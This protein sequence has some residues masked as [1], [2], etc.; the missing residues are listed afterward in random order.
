MALMQQSKLNIVPGFKKMEPAKSTY[1]KFDLKNLWEKV[2]SGDKD[3]LGR[4]FNQCFDSL[5]GYGYRITPDSENVR[6]AIQEIFFQV[7]KYRKKLSVPDSVEAY[8]F[9]S[10]RRE[11]LNKKKA[12]QRR[13]DI[14]NKYYLEEFDALI[15]YNNWNE[16]LNL[17]EEDSKKLK[18]SIENLTPRQR[19]VIYLKF[20]EGFSTEE[21]SQILDLHAQS[22]YNLVFSAI[23]QLRFFL[24]N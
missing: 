19:E 14:D 3:A 2:L 16:I 11:L 13:D 22:I 8:L 17:E 10:L 21:L 5:Y 12:S 4:L 20:Y 6:D 15:S 24:D 1:H 9:I 18:R 23:N 7:W